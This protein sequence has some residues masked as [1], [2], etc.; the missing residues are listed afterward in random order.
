[1]AK[2]TLRPATLP[3]APRL[4]QLLHQ[5]VHAISPRDYSPAQLSAWSPA[6]MD[7]AKMRARLA[8][9]RMVWVAETALFIA[10]F[11]ELEPS[12]DQSVGHIDCFYRTPEAA[13]QGVGQALYAA[14]ETRARKNGLGT[15]DVEASEPARRFFLHQGFKVTARQD[16][17]RAGVPL[18]NFKMRKAIR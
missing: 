3:D 11:I 18:H 13:G 10:G 6:P 14:L 2:L 12:E 9:G 17:I 4:A 1:M 15:L 16:L 5:S 8:D 7:T